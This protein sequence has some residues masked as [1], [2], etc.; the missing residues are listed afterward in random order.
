M[1]VN[2]GDYTKCYYRAGYQG[3]IK[4]YTDYTKGYSGLRYTGLHYRLEQYY[5]NGNNRLY[6]YTGL[7][8]LN[9]MVVIA[10]R[11]LELIKSI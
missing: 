1:G 11:L 3:Y 10:T 4:S 7:L 9:R 2:R 8:R 5:T 6:I